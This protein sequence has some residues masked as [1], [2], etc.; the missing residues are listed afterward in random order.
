MEDIIDV[1]YVI[2]N[3]LSSITLLIKMIILNERRKFPK[4][5][6]VRFAKSVMR[7]LR[8]REQS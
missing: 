7:R 8:K 1:K 6:L 3:M 5:G 2:K 4:R